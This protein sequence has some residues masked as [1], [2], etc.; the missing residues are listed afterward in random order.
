MGSRAALMANRSDLNTEQWFGLR[1]LIF[2]MASGFLMT[3]P[4]PVLPLSNKTDNNRT[5]K[6]PPSHGWYQQNGPGAALELKGDRKLQTAITRLISGHTR[7][8]TFVQD[9][10]TF[11]VCL[12]CNVDQVSSEHFLS[13]IAVI[14]NPRS[15]DQMVPGRL[16][17]IKLLPFYLKRCISLEF[18]QL[19]TEITLYST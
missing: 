4:L 17:N 12:K 19:S 11:P 15:V 10:K 9:Q 13:C 2:V 6:T 16:K 8:L 3:T 1:L 5:W 18:A 14:R 7:G